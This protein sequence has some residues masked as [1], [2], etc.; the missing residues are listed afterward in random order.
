MEKNSLKEDV[1][2]LLK[3]S[4]EDLAEMEYLFKGN[5]YYGTANRAYYAM[6][7][8]V[9]ALLLADGKEF[10][11]HQA[12]ISCFG[13]DYAKTGVVPVEFHRSLIDAYDLRQDVDYDVGAS[14]S[15]KQAEE[16]VAKARAIVQFV[17]ELLFKKYA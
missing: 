6:F 1:I 4:K 11:S 8:A 5:Y 9:S 14:V 3:R 7:H 13:K 16:V 17:E 10:S 2:K 12:V 15:E